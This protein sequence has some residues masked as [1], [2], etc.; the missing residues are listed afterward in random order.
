VPPPRQ[1]AENIA[2]GGLRLKQGDRQA[3]EPVR[4]IGI[5]WDCHPPG[6]KPPGFRLRKASCFPASLIGIDF[7]MRGWNSALEGGIPEPIGTSPV[8]ASNGCHTHCPPTPAP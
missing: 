6:R 3:T 4:I 8:C 2:D 7:P 1:A 5:R